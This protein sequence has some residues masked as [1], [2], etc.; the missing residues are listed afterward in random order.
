[1]P[2]GRDADIAT[3]DGEGYLEAVSSNGAPALQHHAG[4]HPRVNTTRL[5]G[6][7]QISTEV[8]KE[9]LSED[10]E[11]NPLMSVEAG[12]RLG[13]WTGRGVNNTIGRASSG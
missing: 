2:S 13:K 9:V 4:S 10:V 1:M 12:T 6:Y 11:S 8:T 3:C 5:V 7:P